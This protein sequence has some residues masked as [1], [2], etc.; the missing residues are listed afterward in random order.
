MASYPL[1]P[2]NVT[3]YGKVFADV[4]K[5]LEVGRLSWFI[6]LGPK[7]NHM[8]SY[9]REA[10]Q[11]TQQK[12]K[13]EQKEVWGC[14]PSKLQWCAMCRRKP[15]AT[16]IWKKQGAWILPRASR[17]RAVTLTPWFRPNH[18]NLDILNSRNVKEYILV[19]LRHFADVRRPFFFCCCFVVAIIYY[20]S[21]RKLLRYK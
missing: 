14:W 21:H 17:G 13:T 1:E 3:F 4:I 5:N 2:V 15:T 6:H 18:T 9:K 19:V 7:C 16:R 11:Y 8:C 12:V 20:S 10:E